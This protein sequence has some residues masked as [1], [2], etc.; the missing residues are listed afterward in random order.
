MRLVIWQFMFHVMI[1]HQAVQPLGLLVTI[2]A[3]AGTKKED[4]ETVMHELTEAAN[5]LNVDIIGDIPR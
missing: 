5:S 1:L 4:I 2:L 3:P